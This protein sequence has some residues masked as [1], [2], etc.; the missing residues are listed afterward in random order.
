MIPIHRSRPWHSLIPLLL[1]LPLFGGCRGEGT[2][3]DS[4]LL[5]EVAISPTPPAVGSARLIISL[6]DTSGVPLSGVVI[7]VEGNMSHAGMVPVMATA[8]EVAAGQYSVADF[9]FTMAGDWVLTLKATLPDGRTT[10]IQHR[11]D[12]ASQTGGQDAG[13]GAFP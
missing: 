10:Q 4:G 5:L 12:V 6:R 3:R 1:L 7:S 13:G 8:E 2:Q 9:G 11:T